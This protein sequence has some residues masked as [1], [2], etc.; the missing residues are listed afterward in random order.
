MRTTPERYT[1][2]NHNLLFDFGARCMR[3]VLAGL[4][5]KAPSFCSNDF[6]EDVYVL[7][8]SDIANTLTQATVY[9]YGNQSPIESGHQD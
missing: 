8:A 1:S 5:V 3:L 7:A 4:A 9:V 6:D 2:I